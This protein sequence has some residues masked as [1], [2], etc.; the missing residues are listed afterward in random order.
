MVKAVLPT[1]QEQGLMF[2]TA[3]EGRVALVDEVDVAEVAAA[4]LTKDGH[5]GK[6]YTLTG[7]AKLSYPDMADALAQK[8]GKPVEYVNITPAQAKQAMVAAGLPGW[9]ADFVNDLR[10]FEQRGEASD[11]TEDVQNVLGRPTR[12]FRFSIDAVLG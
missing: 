4:A 7:P 5:E 6:T 12:P 10:A 11:P 3:G 8:L 9:V 2:S 1:V